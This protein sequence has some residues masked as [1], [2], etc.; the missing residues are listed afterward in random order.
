[1][2]TLNNLL[3]GI[4]GTLSLVSCKP[5]Q[6]KVET[7]EYKSIPTPIK[8]PL[9]ENIFDA[10]SNIDD[11][12]VVVPPKF[13]KTIIHRNLKVDFKDELEKNFQ[14]H[15]IISDIDT[16]VVFKEGTKLTIKANTFVTENGEPVSGDLRIKVNEFYQMSDII[17]G[18]LTTTCKDQILE[19]GGM[20][21]ISVTSNGDNCKIKP[22]SAIDVAFP[23]QLEKEGMKLFSGKQTENGIDWEETGA[24]DVSPN[25]TGQ[26]MIYFTIVEQ[27][28]FF[29]LDEKALARY[30]KQKI[31][32][33]Y[34]AIKMKNS[35]VVYT[36]FFVSR[37]GQVTN[38]R[39][40]K[41]VS[42]ELDKTAHYILENMP[43]WKPA[44]QQGKAVGVQYML[45]IRF[46]LSNSFFS[47][48]AIQMAKEFEKK[49]DY[50]DVVYGDQGFGLSDSS[51][52]VVFEEEIDDAALEKMTTDEQ[53]YYVFRTTKLGWINCDRF[54][55]DKSPRT[56]FFVNV[57]DAF[58]TDVKIIFEEFNSVLGGKVIKDK[59]II[60]NVPLGR[61]VTIVAVK[62]ENNQLFLAIKKSKI[63]IEGESDLIF[64]PVTLQELRE[65][66][67]KLNKS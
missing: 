21:N 9:F 1:M 29:Q 16:T 7:S 49:I 56:D 58:N 11:T 15:T 26:Q 50:I 5:N 44:T 55:Y 4:I 43:I 8:E 66:M 17:L 41:G 20:V 47:K 42:P 35:G 46:S 38:I 10:T 22:G 18:N 37:T 48:Q 13:N 65:E 60:N 63:S 45:P 12:V 25:T 27:S 19:T 30:L 34:T 57:G 2:K 62:N 39:I 28:P 52:S 51:G 3:I 24:T 6:N 14:T 53:Q 36:S 31:Q 32:Y 67:K 59:Y 23:F 33:P 64:K 40:L 61:P 54:F